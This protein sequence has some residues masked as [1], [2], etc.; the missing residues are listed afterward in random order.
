MWVKALI[1]GTRDLGLPHLRSLSSS[2]TRMWLEQPYTFVE[3]IQ[4]AKAGKANNRCCT[5]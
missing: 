4:H 5:G 1:P 2:V 3:K